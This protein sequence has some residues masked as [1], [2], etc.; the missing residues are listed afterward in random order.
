M[1][2]FSSTST[3]NCTYTGDFSHTGGI[4]DRIGDVFPVTAGVLFGTFIVLSG[5]ILSWISSSKA[6]SGIFNF[7]YI[8]TKLPKSLLNTWSLYFMMNG[9][10]LA[11]DA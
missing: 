11:A 7:C 3:S 4:K 2:N 9:S 10:I 8:G 1:F 5:N 6:D